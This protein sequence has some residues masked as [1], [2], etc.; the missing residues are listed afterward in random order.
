M[1]DVLG[2]ILPIVYIIVGVGL[3]WFVIELALTIRKARKTVAAI[4][5][6]IEPSLAS[7]QKITADIQPVITKVDPLV[8]RVSLTVDAANLEIM[9]VDQILENVTSITGSVNKAVGAVDTVTS[10]PVDFVNSVTKKV[11]SVFK[12]KYASNE[13]MKLGGAEGA[14]PK[15]PVADLVDASV[16][17]VVDAAKEQRERLAERKAAREEQQAVE[18][19][20]NKDL[21]EK[22]A[23][24]RDVILDSMENEGKAAVAQA[25]QTAEGAPTQEAPQESTETN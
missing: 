5:E 18:A 12:P 2:I 4:Q 1:N 8:E 19:S 3:V 14:E 9:R 20:Q 23:S 16:D 21:S 7:I 25:A 11:R 22:I 24:T 6:E 13:S 17:A 10:A 15:G